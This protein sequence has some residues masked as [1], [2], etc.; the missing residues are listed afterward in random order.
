MKKQVTLTAECL[1]IHDKERPLFRV[2]RSP[3]HLVVLWSK[4]GDFQSM[5]AQWEFPTKAKA[6]EF[7]RRI[8]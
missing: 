1:T 5:V 2:K 6:A 4:H 3:Q 8:S 7:Y